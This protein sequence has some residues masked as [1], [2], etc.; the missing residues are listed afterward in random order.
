MNNKINLM[1]NI[2]E[3]LMNNKTTKEVIDIISNSYKRGLIFSGVGKNWYVCQKINKTIISLGINSQTLDVVHAIHGDIGMIQNQFIFF[4]SKSG[5]TEELLTLINYLVKIREK[6]II[7]P[8][9][10]GVFLENNSPIIDKLDYIICP[11]DFQELYEFDSKNIVPTLSINIL[12]MLLDYIGIQ[13]FEN[14]SKLVKIYKYHHPAGLI[15]K[16]LN[17]DGELNLWM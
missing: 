5:K 3:E 15:G 14:N 13:I 1:F 16:N 17:I 8:T 7:N 6:N 2:F 11:K 9:L 10:I 12:Q 4:I